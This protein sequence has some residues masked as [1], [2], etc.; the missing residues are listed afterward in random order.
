MKNSDNEIVLGKWSENNLIES[1]QEE[2][3]G[4]IGKE[5]SFTQE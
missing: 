3:D 1:Y 5:T 4:V 2:E